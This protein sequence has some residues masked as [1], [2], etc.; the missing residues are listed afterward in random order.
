[1]ESYQLDVAHRSQWNWGETEWLALFIAQIWSRTHRFPRS[2]QELEAIDYQEIQQD[3]EEFKQGQ[4]TYQPRGTTLEEGWISVSILTGQ[5]HV[6]LRSAQEYWPPDEI[7]GPLKRDLPPTDIWK[8]VYHSFRQYREQVASLSFAE[9]KGLPKPG[10]ILGMFL[11][12]CAHTVMVVGAADKGRIIFYDS[13][14]KGKTRS[15]LSKGQN[16]VGIKATRIGEYAWSITKREFVDSVL[17][18][19][20]PR[21]SYNHF[22][23]R[24]LGK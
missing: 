20:T 15:L 22:S 19:V 4:G 3:F 8:H 14:Q 2:Q 23:P 5:I 21:A 1:M 12:H 16:A 7:P 11:G 6:C 9:M 24:I 17:S 13:W 18:Y 10:G